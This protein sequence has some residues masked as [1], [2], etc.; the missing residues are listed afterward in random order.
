[1]SDVQSNQPVHPAQL[2]PIDEKLIYISDWLRPYGQQAKWHIENDGHGGFQTWLLL[3]NYAYH[4]RVSSL[5]EATAR[6]V[7]WIQEIEQ[8]ER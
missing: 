7:K 2:L 8:H 1:M 5:T 6:T 4:E 3:P